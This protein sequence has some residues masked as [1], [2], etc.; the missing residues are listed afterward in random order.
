[1]IR[2]PVFKI[3]AD[4]FPFDVVKLGKAE[5]EVTARFAQSLLV[6]D[7]QGLLRG[8]PKMIFEFVT[9]ENRSSE[10]IRMNGRSGL[11]DFEL[12]VNLCCG[13]AFGA[14]GGI[15]AGCQ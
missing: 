10:A 14:D 13:S 3:M 6:E 11:S 7:L 9:A 1:M 2:F 5:E 8:T 4:A 12:M 15:A